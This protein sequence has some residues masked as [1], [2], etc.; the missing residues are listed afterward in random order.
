MQLNCNAK[1]SSVTLYR[2][3][4]CNDVCAALHDTMLL[5]SVQPKAQRLAAMRSVLSA[6]QFSDAITDMDPAVQVGDSRP[7]AQSIKH[8]AQSSFTTVMSVLSCWVILS[9]NLKPCKSRCPCTVLN[10]VQP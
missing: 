1:S 9:A 5:C 4:S 8:S 7:L 10:A 6:E 3:H 2:W